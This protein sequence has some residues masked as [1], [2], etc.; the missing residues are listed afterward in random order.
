VGFDITGDIYSDA[1]VHAVS[2]F[3]RSTRLPVTGALDPLTA[4]QLGQYQYDLGDRLLYRQDPPLV[5]HDVAELQASLAQLGFDPGTVDGLFGNDTDH[6]LRDFQ[7]NCGLEASGTLTRATLTELRRLRPTVPKVTISEARESG[8]LQARIAGPLVAVGGYLATT[9]ADAWSSYG[10]SL[11]ATDENGL[12]EAAN[13]DHA[14]LAI[15][16]ENSSTP[17][18]TY[19]AGPHSF[20]TTGLT[21]ATQLATEL[22]CALRGIDDTFLRRTKMTALILSV[23]DDFDAVKVCVKLSEALSISN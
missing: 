16:I 4:Q 1:T 11:S 9:M 13:S 22:S 6:A 7:L 12:I 3:Q 2:A 8:L 15:W 19:F 17:A 10:P 23:T 5:G 14:S 18:V 21:L 20:S